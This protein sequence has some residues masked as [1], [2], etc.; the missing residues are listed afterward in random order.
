VAKLLGKLFGDLPSS[1]TV[2]LFGPFLFSFKVANNSVAS[3]LLLQKAFLIKCLGILVLALFRDAQQCGQFMGLLEVEENTPLC[4]FL[5]SFGFED[6]DALALSS[7]E[8]QSSQNLPP[9][10]VHGTTHLWDGDPS[11]YLSRAEVHEAQPLPPLPSSLGKLNKSKSC[12]N[13]QIAYPISLL[14][15][16]ICMHEDAP[17]DPPSCNVDPC[18]N[19]P[20]AVHPGKEPI[21]TH[22]PP[23]GMLV[24]FPT[25]FII[26]LPPL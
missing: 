22:P 13:L 7:S 8:G 18:N 19:L 16:L 23:P 12:P 4:P 15:P 5:N 20:R 24:M 26:S 2:C 17:R 11:S 10:V 21:R 6:R 9:L 1:F 3:K 14:V 25:L